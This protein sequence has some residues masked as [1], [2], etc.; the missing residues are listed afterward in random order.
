MKYLY[1][2]KDKVITNEGH[3]GTINSLNT[4]QVDNKIFPSYWVIFDDLHPDGCA[5]NIWESSIKQKL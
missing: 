1:R 3:I 5:R 2:K 4:S